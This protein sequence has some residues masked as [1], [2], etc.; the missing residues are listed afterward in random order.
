MTRS[1]MLRRSMGRC[2]AVTGDGLHVEMIRQC[3]NALDET[4]RQPFELD[5]H[6]AADASSRNPLHQQALNQ[7]PRVIRDEI[8][9]KAFDKFASAVLTL[10][11][12]LTVVN[13]TIS[14]ILRRSSS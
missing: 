3:L 11:V 13:V 7:S 1:T 9:L 8:L 14:L 10:M 2:G 5:P 4:T 6:S 12:L